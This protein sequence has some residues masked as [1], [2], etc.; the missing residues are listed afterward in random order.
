MLLE[1]FLDFQQFFLIVVDF[2]IGK[3][4]PLSV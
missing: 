3:L 4:S 2:I 1:L